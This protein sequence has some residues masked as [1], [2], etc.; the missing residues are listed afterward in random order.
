M[1]PAVKNLTSTTFYG[2]RFTRKQITHIQ[3]TVKAF[4]ALSRRELAHTL[5][6]HFNWL[7]ANGRNKIQ[8]CLGA[9]AA[10]QKLGIITL[11]ALS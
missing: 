7:T 3:D 4:P 2:K 11:P 9:L 6:E 10:L 8:S 1:D 5:C